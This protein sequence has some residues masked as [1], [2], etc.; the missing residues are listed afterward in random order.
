MNQKDLRNMRVMRNMTKEDLANL[1]DL[2]V[3]E[4]ERIETYRYD[5]KEE[6]DELLKLLVK[7]DIQ[8][9][10]CVCCGKPLN[11]WQKRFCSDSCS[12]EEEAYRK[13]IT[14]YKVRRKN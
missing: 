10:K 14:Y 7:T 2:T 1:A 3:E 6:Y 12:K 13:K 5:V 11:K 4:I 8:P 9:P